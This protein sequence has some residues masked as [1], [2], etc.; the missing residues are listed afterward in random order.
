MLSFN[1]AGEVVHWMRKANNLL[2]ATELKVELISGT[3][4][5]HDQRVGKWVA[6]RKLN[7]AFM[8]MITCSQKSLKRAQNMCTMCAIMIVN[9]ST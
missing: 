9:D 4:Y 3:C 8:I 6:C 1:F 5:P 7:V 2:I